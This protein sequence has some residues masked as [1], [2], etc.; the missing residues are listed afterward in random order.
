MRGSGCQIEKKKASIKSPFG[1]STGMA[2]GCAVA[3]KLC[4]PGFRRVCLYRGP[5]EAANN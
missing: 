3:S 4:V 5:D 2:L 1:G